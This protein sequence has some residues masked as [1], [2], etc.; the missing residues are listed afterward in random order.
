LELNAEVADV[1]ELCFLNNVMGG[2][3]CDGRE[4]TYVNQLAS[5]DEDPCQRSKWF[6]CA[7]CPPNVTRILGYL[8][9][10]FWTVIP[11]ESKDHFT[12]NVHM[13]GAATLEIPVGDRTIK[14]QQQS[15]WPWKG[16]IHFKVDIPSD[17]S[18][19]INFRIPQYLQ[20]DRWQVS[21]SF[22]GID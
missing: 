11:S 13:Y 12:V 19:D 5:S 21:A 2:M 6:T 14:I 18:V 15:E 4:F 9:G 8:G 3:S 17:I 10:F 20:A 1:M 16:D 22:L 7:C